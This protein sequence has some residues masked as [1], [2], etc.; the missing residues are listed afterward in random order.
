MIPCG[1][2]VE[3]RPE[4]C[5]NLGPFS[6]TWHGVMT[7]DLWGTDVYIPNILPLSDWC[8]KHMMTMVSLY[9]MLLKPEEYEWHG[10][11][12]HLVGSTSKDYA[13]RRP[14]CILGF[15]L[16]CDKNC[17]ASFLNLVFYRTS[18]GQVEWRLVYLKERFC[19]HFQT[20]VHF[21]CLMSVVSTMVDSHCVFAVERA[22]SIWMFANNQTYFQ[23][24]VRR[25]TLAKFVWR[26]LTFS[27]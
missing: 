23:K 2:I 14:P 20:W 21:K 25:L 22:T 18:W 7:F 13:R 17:V 24:F 8:K 11:W 6:E 19:F 16:E 9:S 26:N 5:M 15:W 4:S 3:K 27:C 12:V 10:G 1:N